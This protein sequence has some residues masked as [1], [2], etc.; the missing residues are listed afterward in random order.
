M[1]AETT[2]VANLF[3]IAV[4]AVVCAWFIGNWLSDRKLKRRWE[5][6]GRE[7]QRRA[8]EAH[9]KYCA[10]LDKQLNPGKDT[11]ES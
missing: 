2:I 8:E 11:W 3:Q 1:K 6:E 10:V 5:E 4:C 9:R 7:N